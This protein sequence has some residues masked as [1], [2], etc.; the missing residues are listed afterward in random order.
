MDT[1]LLWTVIAGVLLA[2]LFLEIASDMSYEIIEW[3]R[4]RKS[5]Q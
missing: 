3:W 5:E 1:N 2:N 4:K